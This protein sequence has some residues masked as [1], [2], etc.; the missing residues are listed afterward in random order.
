MKKF[1]MLATL[2]I[3]SSAFCSS[4]QQQKLPNAE[5]FKKLIVNAKSIEQ[6]LNQLTQ[7]SQKNEANA[8][9]ET[10]QS[11]LREAYI[12]S[13]STNMELTYNKILEQ[14][15]YEARMKQLIISFTKNAIERGDKLEVLV[16]N[17]DALQSAAD[18]FK[19][20]R[21]LKKPDPVCTACGL[22]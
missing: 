11:T 12:N 7:G 22:L 2:M 6:Q 19:S 13:D 9:L 14:Q 5:Q 8:T 3:T 18:Q 10:I 4:Q 21:L 1:F 16:K 17:S 15:K 20:N